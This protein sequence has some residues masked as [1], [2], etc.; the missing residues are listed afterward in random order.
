[1]MIRSKDEAMDALSAV[2]AL[3][4][5]RE[6]IIQI[7]VHVAMCLDPD[8]RRFLMDS[9]AGLIEGGLEYMRRKRQEMVEVAP[10]AEGGEPILI[11]DSSTDQLLEAVGSSMDALRLSDVV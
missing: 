4:E 3:T 6:Q 10:P 5:R 11:V 1:M 7:T 8:A 2:L 9:Q